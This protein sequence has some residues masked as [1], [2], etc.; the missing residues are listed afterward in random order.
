MV[1]DVHSFQPS[2]VACKSFLGTKEISF[3][4]ET[5]GYKVGRVY[6]WEFLFHI[7]LYTTIFRQSEY[8]AV[9]AHPRPK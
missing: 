3:L 8:F 9:C 7:L 1:S 4:S 6:L 5:D 2:C